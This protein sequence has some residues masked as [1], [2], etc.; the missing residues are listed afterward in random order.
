[1][2][3]FIALLLLHHMGMWEFKYIFAACV[4]WFLHLCWQ[5]NGSTLSK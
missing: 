2:T 1:V 5:A 4:L 3:L